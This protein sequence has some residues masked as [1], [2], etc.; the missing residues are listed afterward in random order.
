MFRRALD[1]V[2]SYIISVIVNVCV[3]KTI[4]V[5]VP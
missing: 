4:P 5:S 2:F 1:Y 3:F